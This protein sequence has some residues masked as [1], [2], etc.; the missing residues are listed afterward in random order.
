GWKE[1]LP[2]EPLTSI[3]C[4][5]TPPEGADVPGPM[6]MRRVPLSLEREALFPVSKDEASQSATSN[7]DLKQA[8]DG[9]DGKNLPVEAQVEGLLYALQRHAWSLPS[10]L[11]AVSLYDVARTHGAVV[12]AL[13]QGG[14]LFLLGGDLSGVQ[15]FIYTLTAA[16]ATKQLRGRS[17]YLQL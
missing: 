1:E 11:E 15:E 16:G 5:V 6:F 3:F 13:A 2:N 14:E 8:S 17:F 10:P 4:R 12:A 9:I 7:E